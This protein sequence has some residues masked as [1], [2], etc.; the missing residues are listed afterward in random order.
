M[1]NNQS[2][3]RI[4]SGK[5]EF[6]FNLNI[7]SKYQE[8]LV[9]IPKFIIIYDYCLISS[10][11]FLEFKKNILSKL[12][13]NL[14]IEKIITMQINQQNYVNILETN[15]F[16]CSELINSFQ[17]NIK[18][19]F[20]Q[21]EE[22]FKKI[23]SK[24]INILVISNGNYAKTD[25]SYINEIIS[26]ISKNKSINLKVV[27][28]NI[29]QNNI[30]FNF[31]FFLKLNNYKNENNNI[32]ELTKKS[33]GENIYKELY[34]FYDYKNLKSGWKIIRRGNKILKLPFNSTKEIQNS[35][36]EIF[37]ANFNDFI[38]SISQKVAI[39]KTLSNQFSLRQNESIILLCKDLLNLSKSKK[40]KSSYECIIRG[41]EKINNDK[42]ISKLDNNKLSTYI[43]KSSEKIIEE[44]NKMEKKKKDE[45]FINNIETI[46]NKFFNKTKDKIIIDAKNNEKLKFENNNKY[47]NIFNKN[48][49]SINNKMTKK[50]EEEKNKTKYINKDNKIKLDTNQ[51]KIEDKSFSYEKSDNIK[52][53]NLSKEEIN[54]LKNNLSKSV[55][56]LNSTII[57]I[58]DASK[59]MKDHINNLINNLLYNLLKKLNYEEKEKIY[60]LSYNSEDVEEIFMPISKLCKLDIET[61]GERDIS[62]VLNRLYEIFNN[63]NGRNFRVLFFIS[64]KLYTQNLSLSQSKLFFYENKTQKIKMQIIKYIINDQS[65]FDKEDENLFDL[66]NSI[67]SK[68][69]TKSLTIDGNKS[70]SSNIDN[71]IKKLI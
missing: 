63:N 7:S 64:G 32:I 59:Y 10:E 42:Q 53:N 60:L 48:I 18:D 71:I 6:I 52:S 3:I 70:I 4:P 19:I 46:S 40:I 26:K 16:I 44:K 12:F 27:K 41:L 50:K 37:F 65:I 69:K 43:N 47:K 30:N 36:E 23:K 68:I 11:L 20:I 25:D 49:S 38:S 8:D 62:E 58:I 35:N 17:L 1:M 51:S 9:D 28:L 34:D 5:D 14:K 67:N 66:L 45:K 21:L 33:S 22:L 61:E 15:E 57:A 24:F 54:K 29:L 55:K 13:K 31:N 56:P 39:N 2:S